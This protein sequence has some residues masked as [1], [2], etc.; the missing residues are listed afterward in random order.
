MPIVVSLSW[1]H[2]TP[3]DYDALDELVR[4]EEDPP[5]GAV[6]HTAWFTESG[7]RVVDVWR[8]RQDFER[9]ADERLMTAAL[10][11][12]GF[13]GEPLVKFHRLH[14]HVLAPATADV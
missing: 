4:Y 8:T 9:F 6:S 2:V 3:D 14:A 13:H 10:Q 11:V 5:E 1:P 7:L 12:S